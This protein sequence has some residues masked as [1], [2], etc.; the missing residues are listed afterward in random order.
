MNSKNLELEINPP[1]TWEE[2]KT[3]DDI[4]SMGER[5]IIKEMEWVQKVRCPHLKIEGEFFYYCGFNLH[6]PL[7]KKLDAN[8]TVYQRHVCASEISLWCMKDYKYCCTYTGKL[9][10]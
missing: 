2:I 6:E 9:K 10:R 3:F 7:D 5:L 4:V 1:K 8:N